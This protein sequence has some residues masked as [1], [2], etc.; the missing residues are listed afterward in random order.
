[1]VDLVG[2][3]FWSRALPERLAARLCKQSS[4]PL[5][6]RSPVIFPENL[7]S[8][9]CLT[10]L[11]NP[12]GSAPLPTLNTSMVGLTD[13]QTR[14]ASSPW[15]A[16]NDRPCH[17]AACSRCQSKWYVSRLQICLS[18]AS[19]KWRRDCQPVFSVGDGRRPKPSCLFR[20]KGRRV[21]AHQ[22]GSTARRAL[23][24]T[25]PMQCRLS[26]VHRGANGR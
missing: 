14:L 12:T 19:Q 11:W 2:K 7:V 3:S 9:R 21:L 22:V 13:L 4:K 1:M 8:I 15:A 17:L 26:S 5:A 24:A 20:I 25:G 16:S 10:S 23:P 6:L 18:I